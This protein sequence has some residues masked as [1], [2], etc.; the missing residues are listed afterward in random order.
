MLYEQDLVKLFKDQRSHWTIKARIIYNY[1]EQI[2]T[3]NRNH[4]A[5]KFDTTEPIISDYIRLSYALKQ[6]PTLAKIPTKLE[7]LKLLDST[8]DRIELSRN[9]RLAVLKYKSKLQL[10]EIRD[11]ATANIKKQFKSEI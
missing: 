5:W 10:K 11:N 2:P 6:F 7:A 9:I 3:M 4:I 1:S 8:D